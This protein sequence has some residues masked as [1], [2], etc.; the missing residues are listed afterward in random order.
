MQSRFPYENI[1]SH[2]TVYYCI[3]NQD[4]TTIM[5]NWQKGR[6]QAKLDK[7]RTL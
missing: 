4:Q 3:Q 7:N 2:N 5:D 6:N 1:L